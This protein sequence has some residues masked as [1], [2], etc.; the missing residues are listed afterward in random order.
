M[1]LIFIASL[2]FLIFR[3]IFKF[4]TSFK[5]NI[6]LLL[7]FISITFFLF[8][9]LPQIT[10]KI[11][12]IWANHSLS[13]SAYASAFI[14]FIILYI[15]TIFYSK[16]ESYLFITS[17][18]VSM[19]VFSLLIGSNR[20]I[21]ICFF[22]FLIFGLRQNG[23]LNFGVILLCIY[24]AIKS[25]GLFYSIYYCNSLNYEKDAC[26]VMYKDPYT[27]LYLENPGLWHNEVI[28]PSVLGYEFIIESKYYKI[29]K[30]DE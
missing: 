19:F 26:Q 10:H 15:L 25:Y 23:G 27:R 5:I 6:Y 4:F 2:S 16:K 24:F 20:L 9:Y 17:F 14:K 12:S 13:L 3:E 22:F 30:I 8:L 18:F 21:I 1:I 28:S 7:F 29:Y 11:N